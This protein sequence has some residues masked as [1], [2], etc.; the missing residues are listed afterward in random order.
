M[1]LDY[2]LLIIGGVL[3]L[4]ALLLA[5]MLFRSRKMSLEYRR[6]LQ[7]ETERIDLL[8]TLRE[9]YSANSSEVDKNNVKGPN[10]PTTEV[11]TGSFMAEDP[12]VGG[13]LDLTPLDGKYRLIREIS[14]GGMSRI[15][16]AENIKLGNEW[17]VKY[18]DGHTGGLV[19]EAE[20][21]KRLKERS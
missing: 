9:T 4:T 2:L 10:A 8:S 13:N 7:S 12:I 14:G 11:L 18:I 16:L 15:F 20:V 17:I 1:F 6:I 5:V 21:L 19:E 3:L